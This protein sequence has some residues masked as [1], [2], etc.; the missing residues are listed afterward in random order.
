MSI[1]DIVYYRTYSRNDNGVREHWSDTAKRT[2]SH[3]IEMGNFT[4]EEEELIEQTEL[5][6]TALSSGRFL[7]IGGTEWL[8]RGEENH[9]GAYNCTSFPC[10]SWEV[11][12]LQC[13][14]GMMGCGTGI[15]LEPKFT[16]LMDP[17]IGECKSLEFIGNFGDKKKGRKTSIYKDGIFYIGDSREGWTD[18]FRFIFKQFTTEESFNLKINLSNVRAEGSKINGFGGTTRSAQLTNTVEK[19]TKV[20]NSNSGVPSPSLCAEI[21]GWI[22]LMVVAGNVRR[23][24][25]MRQFSPEDTEAAALKQNLWVQNEDGW[26]I[27]PNRTWAR[28]ANH[29][30]VYHTRPSKEQCIESVKNQFYSGEGAIQWAGEAVA[31]A[32]ADIL[33]NDLLKKQFLELYPSSEGLTLAGAKENELYERMN[34]YG[35]NPCGEI[36]GNAFFC[37]LSEIHLN[38]I[39]PDDLSAQ[40]NAFRAGALKAAVLLLQNFDRPLYQNS[41]DKD[42]IIGVSFTGLF[43]FFVNLFGDPWYQWMLSGRPSGTDFP[44]QERAYLIRWRRIV[45][46]TIE[47]FCRR[48][49]IKMPNRYTTV[50]PSGTKSLLTGASPGWHPPKARYFIRR[51]TFGANDP[52]AKAALDA[53]YK[54]TPG[55]SDLDEDGNLSNDLSTA[56]EWLVESPEKVSWADIVTGEP[57]D[58]PIESQFGLY[59][60]VQQYWTSHNT[61][62][63]LEVEEHE[64][65]KLG[66]LIYDSITNDKGYISAAILGKCRETFPRM[67]YE[68]ISKEEYE[69]RIKSIRPISFS[70]EFNGEGP[71]GCDSDYCT[72]RGKNE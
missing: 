23:T 32:N 67:P 43:D 46:N 31:R 11:L 68:P 14:L 55:Q 61:S 24:A 5:D 63:T 19:I 21:A 70:M 39:D 72:L 62:A 56:T 37:N 13:D 57:I 45:K 59:M 1:S 18:L 69:E 28:M 4:P 7:W 58:I 54:L 9:P 51:I 71:A 66:E 25:G 40:D 38:K 47:D 2:T 15:I 64:V 3:I 17:I 44:S 35:L 53:G 42:P 27:D 30:M 33:K 12:A 6:K 65:E 16:N 52:I 26:S 49:N 60:A 10:N 29:T 20:M 36:I 8:K 48:H 50:Q 41:R 34:R 22:G